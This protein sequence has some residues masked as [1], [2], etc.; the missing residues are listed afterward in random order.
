MS[1][2]LVNLIEFCFEERWSGSGG[3]NAFVHV[4]NFHVHIHWRDKEADS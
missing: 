1:Q 3:A 2:G 4:D